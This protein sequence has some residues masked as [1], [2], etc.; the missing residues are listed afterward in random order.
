MHLY[1]YHKIYIDISLARSPRWAGSGGGGRRG[2]PTGG[3]CPDPG[4][5][6]GGITATSVQVGQPGVCG[7]VW[8]GRRE[9]AG[10]GEGGGSGVRSR[11]CGPCRGSSRRGEAPAPLVSQRRSW[12]L[13]AAGWGREAAPQGHPGHPDAPSLP[14][15]VLCQQRCLGLTL[16]SSGCCA[17]RGH[18]CPRAVGVSSCRGGGRLSRFPSP[19]PNPSEHRGGG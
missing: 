4:G 12:P 9:D 5:A 6:G 1:S 18:R 10:G 8:A 13:L 19:L 17:A 2:V 16:P 14:Q 15:T 11:G 3:F 7:L